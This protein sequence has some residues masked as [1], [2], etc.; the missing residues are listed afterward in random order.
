[1]L[2]LLLNQLAKCYLPAVAILVAWMLLLNQLVCSH[3]AVV[4]AKVD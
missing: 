2:L 1:M 4:A 3:L